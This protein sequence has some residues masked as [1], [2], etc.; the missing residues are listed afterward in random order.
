MYTRC[1]MSPDTE[2]Y[3]ENFIDN[4]LTFISRVLLDKDM[5]DT[6]L[7]LDEEYGKASPLNSISKIQQ[8]ISRAKSKENI[9]WCLNTVRDLMDY[10]YMSGGELTMASL[11]K[12]KKQGVVDTWIYKRRFLEYMLT[13]CL[14]TLNFK[15]D[16]RDRLKEVLGN[17]KDYRK[18]FGGA[19][20]IPADDDERD[21]EDDIQEDI[22]GRDLTWLTFW[23]PAERAFLAFMEA[24]IMPPPHGPCPL[25]VQ[26][27]PK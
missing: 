24:P 25:A 22:L 1:E 9:K 26:W 8:I 20:V 13:V 11:G 6:M 18:T 21:P 16:V 4:A 14:E 7:Y 5:F 15:A 27:D 12:G 3:T 10:K 17:H 2:P 19:A 23:P